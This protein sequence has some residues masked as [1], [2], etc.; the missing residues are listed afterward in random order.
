MTTE[1]HCFPGC[2]ALLFALAS[3]CAGD[4]GNGPAGAVTRDTVGSLASA[5]LDALCDRLDTELTKLATDEFECTL[6]GIFTS[7]DQSDCEQIRETCIQN[8]GDPLAADPVACSLAEAVDDGVEGCK[9]LNV[10]QLV[11]CYE[12]TVTGLLSLTCANS[13]DDANSHACVAQ[14]VEGCTYLPQ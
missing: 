3:S 10:D 4:D 1:R 2:V 11:A 12:S 9:A 13:E 7:R 14:R 5:D 6:R 8:G